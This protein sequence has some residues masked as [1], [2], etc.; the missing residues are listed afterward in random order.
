MNDFYNFTNLGCWQQAKELAVEMYRISTDGNLKDDITMRN[1]LR[2]SAISVVS[3]IAE[4]KEIGVDSE[5]IKFLVMAKTSAAGLRTRLIISRD[6]GYLAEG[7]FLDLEDKLIRILA[8]IG[9]LI[10]S[11]KK[12]ADVKTDTR[13]DAKTDV[14]AN[15]KDIKDDAKTDAEETQ[16]VQDIPQ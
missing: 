13:A 12:K 3:N 7:D 15:V 9:G 1:Q 6:L 4:G 5:F 2:E 10:R 8:M 14:K 11:I 16:G